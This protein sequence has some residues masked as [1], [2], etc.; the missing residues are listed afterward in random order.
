M[1]RGAALGELAAN[2]PVNNADPSRSAALL[3]RWE[4]ILHSVPVYLLHFRKSDAF[5][6][7][8]DAKLE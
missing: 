5:W 2:S 8:I 4:G 7:V 1:S 3:A 6:E